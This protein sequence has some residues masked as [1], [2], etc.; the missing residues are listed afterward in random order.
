MFNKELKHWRNEY[1]KGNL[2]DEIMSGKCEVLLNKTYKI[3]RKIAV[4]IITV[5]ILIFVICYILI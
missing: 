2:D 4:V 3:H 5:I 1:K